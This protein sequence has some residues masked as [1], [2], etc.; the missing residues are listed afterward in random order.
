MC[1]E[2]PILIAGLPRSGNTWMQFALSQHPRLHIHGH[3]TKLLPSTL[4][5][6]LD[7]LVDSGRQA[8]KWN[9]G[10][11]Y[12]VPHHAG[13][14][15]EVCKRLFADMLRGFLTGFGPAKPRWGFKS[16]SDSLGFYRQLWPQLRAVVPIRHPRV[17]YE[18]MLNTQQ[19]PPRAEVFCKRWLQSVEVA[20]GQ[21]WSMPWFTDKLQG[22]SLQDRRLQIARVLAFLGEDRQQKV[23]DF[24]ARNPVIH[25]LVPDDDRKKRLNERSWQTLLAEVPGL[26]AAVEEFYGP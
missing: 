19:N 5:Q 13:C 8:A 3:L 24:A 2:S 4:K 11:N 17:T 23:M 21:E 18:S 15:P 12:D 16:L 1:D 14:E 20:N 6:W 10:L 25:K 7:S 26:R 9:A 22:A